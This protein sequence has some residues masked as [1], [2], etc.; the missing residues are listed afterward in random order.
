[1]NALEAA[2]ADVA[3]FLEE[4]PI[5]YMVIGG[6][7]SL[8]WGRP[9]LTEDLDF[10]ILLEEP[11]WPEFV[12]RLGKRYRL[13]APSPLEFARQTRV[14]PIS[15]SGD[16]RADL[17][18]AGIPYEEAAIR[19]AVEVE[20]AGIG[21]RFCTAEDLI[22]YKLVAGR[23]RDLDDVEGVILRVG[24]KLDRAYLD[25]LVDQIAAD[26][27][28]SNMGEFYRRC[29]ERAGISSARRGGRHG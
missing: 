4:S 13:M 10:A 24:S 11:A 12:H 19:R 3:T 1:M 26:P 14:I 22:V 21:V 6:F 2:L 7:A 9:R 5:P 27:E 16:V 28:R 25:P 23:P 8:Q 29:L 20:V 15:T 17:V 18:F